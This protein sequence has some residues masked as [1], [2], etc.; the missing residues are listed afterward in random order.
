MDTKGIEGEGTH[1]FENT[2]TTKRAIRYVPRYEKLR[3]CAADKC[4]TTLRSAI[5]KAPVRTYLQF[6]RKNALCIITK[7][8]YVGKIAMQLQLQL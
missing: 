8:V 4:T 3:A 7:F 1:N 5:V 6:C 2:S